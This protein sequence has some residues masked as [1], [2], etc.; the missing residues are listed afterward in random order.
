[1]TNLY[2]A[3]TSPQAALGTGGT[4]IGLHALG[5]ALPT[6]IN[7]LVAIYTVLLILHKGYQMY[8][9]WKRGN[10]DEQR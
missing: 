10:T 5:E 4:V 1:M 6:I 9:D 3:A 2:D 8:K 7:Y